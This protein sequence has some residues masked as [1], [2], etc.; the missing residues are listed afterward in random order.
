MKDEAC[1]VAIDYHL[2]RR[3]DNVISNHP[4]HVVPDFEQV[5]ELMDRPH[6]RRR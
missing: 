4:M 1:R 3:G 2:A 5:R 6:A